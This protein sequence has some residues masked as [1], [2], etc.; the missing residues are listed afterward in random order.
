[1]CK[2]DEQRGQTVK[3]KEE[4]VTIDY[5]KGYVI[6]YVDEIT[7]KAR[8]FGANHRMS[9]IKDSIREKDTYTRAG[10]NKALANYLRLYPDSGFY[11]IE[12]ISSHYSNFDEEL[13]DIDEK[14]QRL[15]S[16]ISKALDRLDELW[17]K[18]V[19]DNGDK[20]RINEVRSIFKRIKEYLIGD[21]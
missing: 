18:N 1:M 10:A 9:N 7:G 6:R 19:F 15:M 4:P 5:D 8:Y 21:E 13:M 2:S 17:D 12:K 20:M 14:K 11:S 16:D 3:H